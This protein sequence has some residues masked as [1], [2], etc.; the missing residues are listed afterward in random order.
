MFMLHWSLGVL[1]IVGLATLVLVG[2]VNKVATA[3][4]AEASKIA[5]MQALTF[6]QTVFSRSE[7]IRAMGLLPAV[8]DRWGSR[9]ATALKTG[10]EAAGQSSTFYGIS[11]SVRKILQILIMA[12]GAY[13][14]IGGEISGG[15]IFA[16][17][18]ISSR[19]LQPFEQVIGGWDRIS[20]ARMAHSNLEA[21]LAGADEEKNRC[22]FLIQLA[23]FRFRG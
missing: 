4:N 14:V 5:D 21:F 18:M 15:V 7:D 3:Q 22:A 12:W 10:D 16:A 17:S 9:M 6:A 1:T 2:W 20:A 11:K 19:A 23:T 13:L 8:M